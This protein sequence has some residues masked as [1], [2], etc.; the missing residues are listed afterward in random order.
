[1]R[2][3][4][5]ESLKTSGYERLGESDAKHARRCTP[6]FRAAGLVVLGNRHITAGLRTAQRGAAGATRQ[7]AAG[8]GPGPLRIN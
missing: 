4:V 1:M 5:A 6:V 3:P 7:T 8:S 2:H